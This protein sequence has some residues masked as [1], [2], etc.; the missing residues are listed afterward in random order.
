MDFR[1]KEEL[2]LIPH[3]KKNHEKYAIMDSDFIH[4]VVNLSSL[5]ILLLTLSQFERVGTPATCSCVLLSTLA[6]FLE[7]LPYVLA[8]KDASGSSHTL[9]AP[10]QE[11]AI[12]SRSPTSI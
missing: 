8:Q 2:S 9:P 5:V 6:S 11:L 3:F 12:S 4:W 7:H 1:S 10:A